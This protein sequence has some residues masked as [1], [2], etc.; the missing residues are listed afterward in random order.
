[1]HEVTKGWSDEELEKLKKFAAAGYTVLKASLALKRSTS[2]VSAKARE[3][4]TPLK[5]V[6]EAR[7]AQKDREFAI[8]GQR[9]SPWN[10]R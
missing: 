9:P 5:T 1:M 4:R 3:L 8:T 2:G 7:K 10:Y 6:A